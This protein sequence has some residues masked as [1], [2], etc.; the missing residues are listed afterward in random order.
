[1]MSQV[2][3][4]T[5]AR[6]SEDEVKS[7]WQLFH[8]TEAA[9][10]RWHRESSEQFLERLD[11]QDISDEERTF[12]AIAWDSLVQGHG[13]FGRFIGA[14]DTLIHNFQD[15]DA[16]YVATHPKFNTLLTES[17]LLPV[18]LEGYHETK[19][20]IV[21]LEKKNQILAAENIQLQEKAARE[22]SGAW[23]IN[24]LAVG[25]IAALAL[26][27][28]GRLIDAKDWLLEN[29]EGVDIDIPSYQSDTQLNDWAN[30]HQVGHLNHGR[31][32]EIIKQ[33]MPA[34]TQIFNE[35][36]AQGVELAADGFHE[37]VFS[38]IEENGAIK[39]LLNV[40]ADLMQFA[41]NLRGEQN[42]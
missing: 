24:R 7:L 6:P 26:I 37:S 35:A 3:S 18:V 16:D 31:A 36:M 9:E 25:S 11:E 42:A 5:M 23:L 27:Q 13:G 20:I 2:I 4:V 12:I 29:L 15:P 19:N 40:R 30:T 39:P 41:A 32:L 34:T 22:L 28:A 10:D 17:E 33:Q 21:D 38:A 8:A 1:M 14:Y